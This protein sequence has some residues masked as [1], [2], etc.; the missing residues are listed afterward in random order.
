MRIGDTA[1]G[2]ACPYNPN[3]VQLR[4][5]KIAAN[6][7]SMTELVHGRP[8]SE[9]LEQARKE[10]VEKRRAAMRP[11]AAAAAEA[12]MKANQVEKKEVPKKSKVKLAPAWRE[13]GRYD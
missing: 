9:A 1:H 5:D 12:R 6:H 8:I 7:N 13:G 4:A 11:L 3:K 10:S 2:P